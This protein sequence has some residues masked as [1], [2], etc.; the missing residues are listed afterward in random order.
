LK[1][2]NRESLNRCFIHWAQ[3]FFPDKV[4]G[5]TISFDGKTIRSTGKMEKYA[6]P[7]HIVSAHLANLGITIGQQTVDGKTNEIPAMRELLLLLK[8]EGCMIVA[9]ALHCRKE[10]AKVI[11][12]D[13][14]A[15]YLLSVKDNRKGL[16]EDIADYV[17][18]ARLR[19]TMD[20]HSV[21]EK[22]S[23][24]VERRT[25]YAACC[26]D[27]LHGK[28]EWA[29]L[30]CIGAVNTQFSSKKGDTNEWHY[31]ISSRKLTAEELLGHARLEWSVETMH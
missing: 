9:D 30:A 16:M 7:L 26:I 29:N 5:V 1:L 31:Y 27:W 19:A 24:R 25:A 11:V 22:N 10:T 2:V 20:S 21:C 3:S 23:G 17:Q 8:V 14:K 4:E 12:E 15:D 28:D 18:D 13:S 6:S